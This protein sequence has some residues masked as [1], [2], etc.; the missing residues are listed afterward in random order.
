MW[1]WGFGWRMFGMEFEGGEL[2]FIGVGEEK[3]KVDGE[4]EMGI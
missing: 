1:E 3:E 4:S 2:M